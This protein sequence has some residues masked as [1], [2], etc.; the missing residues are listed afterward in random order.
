MYGD[1]TEWECMESECMKTAQ[2][3]NVWRQHG[4]GMRVHGVGMY[5]KCTE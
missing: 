1:S 2:S 3:G 4:V 5:G